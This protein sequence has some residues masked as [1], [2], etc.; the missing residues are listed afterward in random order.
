MYTLASSLCAFF[1]DCH[2]RVFFFLTSSVLQHYLT[3]EEQL[4][5]IVKTSELD[6]RVTMRVP[7]LST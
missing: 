6:E 7:S 3:L 5:H 1:L 2:L 4:Q